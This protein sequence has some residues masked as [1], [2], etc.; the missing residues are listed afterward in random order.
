MGL[1]FGVKWHDH[2]WVPWGSCGRIQKTDCW[3]KNLEAVKTPTVKAR[4][5]EGQPDLRGGNGEEGQSQDTNKL[6][7]ASPGLQGKEEVKDDSG[8]SSEYQV[9][10]VINRTRAWGRWI[11]LDMLNLIST[12]HSGGCPRWRG[13]L[14]SQWY[15]GHSWSQEKED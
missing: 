8:L 11:C 10:K 14:S 15:T 4:D 12:E 2:I 9:N 13:E 5:K 6:A 3:R 7:A 1:W